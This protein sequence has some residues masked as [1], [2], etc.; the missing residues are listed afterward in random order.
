MGTRVLCDDGKRRLCDD[1]KRKKRCTRACGDCEIFIGQTLEVGR[2]TFQRPTF[3]ADIC[4]EG[5]SRYSSIRDVFNTLP[6][7][8]QF[9]VTGFDPFTGE[10]EL[11]YTGALPT[12]L[13]NAPQNQIS[14]TQW[15]WFY[16]RGLAPPHDPPVTM[17]DMIYMAAQALL[18]ARILCGATMKIRVQLSVHV[19]G[20]TD[21]PPWS[22]GSC[23]RSGGVLSPDVEIT[24]PGDCYTE[25]SFT[26]TEPSGLGYMAASAGTVSLE[27]P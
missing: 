3:T 25:Q 15:E 2:P 18:W 23:G 11:E 6:A 17:T 19:E 21:S 12:F 24:D 10:P 4:D 7:T 27:A 22:G 1:G 13:G 20:E 16:Q 14:R 26:W 5:V 9:T 8:L